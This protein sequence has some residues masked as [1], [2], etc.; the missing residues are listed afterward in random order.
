[1]HFNKLLEQEQKMVAMKHMLEARYSD[2]LWHSIS[3]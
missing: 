2:Y 1:M 3:S